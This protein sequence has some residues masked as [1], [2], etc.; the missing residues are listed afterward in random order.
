M[1][2]EIK[3]NLGPEGIHGALGYREEGHGWKES[4]KWCF[5]NHACIKGNAGLFF[6][7]L[8][9]VPLD[10]IPPIS[11]SIHSKADLLC[12]FLSQSNLPGTCSVS[13]L[14]M[15][16]ITMSSGT[17]LKNNHHSE[18]SCSWMLHGLDLISAQ[19]F[20]LYPCQ[21]FPWWNFS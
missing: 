9:S 15:T 19:A 6:W 3:E 1:V 21:T 11:H 16:G 4:L 12:S 7:L 17:Q 18:H 20:P 14:R 5:V 8:Q 10:I 2:L 13:F